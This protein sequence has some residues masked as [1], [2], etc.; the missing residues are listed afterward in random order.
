MWFK[1]GIDSVYRANIIDREVKEWLD[2]IKG[3]EEYPRYST[4]RVTKPLGCDSRYFNLKDGVYTTEEELPGWN[5]KDLTATIE[6]DVLKIHGTKPDNDKKVIDLF[7]CLP[8]DL[9]RD[10]L[11]IK[12]EDGLLEITASV[13][14][15]PVG[16]KIE[17]K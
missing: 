10:T 12:L 3:L 4:I 11:S 1:S 15:K 8:P 5:K 13:V 16:R 2:M 14:K 9:D 7:F 17:I 6:E